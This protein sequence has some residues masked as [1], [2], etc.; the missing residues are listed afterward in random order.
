MADDKFA[1]RGVFVVLIGNLMRNALTIIA[2][3]TLCASLAACGT[4]TGSGNGISDD[5]SSTPVNVSGQGG[6]GNMSG[7][8]LQLTDAPIDNMSEVMIRVLE[9][10]LKRTSGGWLRYTLI[11]P[12]TINLL[13]LQGTSTADLLNNVEADTG[14]YKEIR[15]IVDG[16]PMANYVRLAANGNTYDLNIPSGSSSGMKIKGD[17]TV[18]G[19]GET[20]MVVDFDLRQSLKQNGNSNNYS[21]NPVTR[22]VDIDTAGHVRGTVAASS[23]TAPSCSDGDVDT[24]NA[25]Y[26]YSGAGAATDDINQSSNSNN[27]PFATT[28]IAYDA[29]IGGY[30]YEAAFLPEG[31]YTIAFTCNADVEDLDATENLQFFDIQNVNV[32]ANNTTFL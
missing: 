29:S 4:D 30:L 23:L 3:F 12:A 10:E 17:F 8:S 5:D 25:V 7:F 22:L 19:S 24:H 18:S 27:D 9:I 28:T 2:A 16:T 13:S 20:T 6:S 32:I 11:N 15:L 21:L 1:I 26:I 14:D 31:D